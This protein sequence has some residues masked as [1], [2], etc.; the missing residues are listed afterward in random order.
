MLKG[1]WLLIIINTQIEKNKWQKKNPK[2]VSY[3]MK[4]CRECM[5]VPIENGTIQ[6][7]KIA[8][9]IGLCLRSSIECKY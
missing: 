8:K 3:A 7:N 1:V 5:N 2:F 9:N 6:T 4:S